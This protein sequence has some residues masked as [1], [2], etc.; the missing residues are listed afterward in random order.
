MDD[1]CS[2][3]IKKKMAHTRSKLAEKLETLEEQIIEPT[4][5]AVTETATSVKE[6]V[7]GTAEAVKMVTSALDLSAHVRE[8]PWRMMG[9]GVLTGFLLGHFLK[10]TA[11]EVR[12]QHNDLSPASSQTDFGVQ[13][14]SHDQQ[15][16]RNGA[17]APGKT[18]AESRLAD[19]QPPP[20]T[21]DGWSRFATDI[22][23]TL[24][25]ALAPVCQGLIGAALADF[26]RPTKASESRKQLRE[27]VFSENREHEWSEPD[28]KRDPEWGGRLR[29]TPR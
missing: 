11:S 15:D 13:Q 5:T 23:S 1:P 18:A 25:H 10:P 3:D 4:A 8:H 7:G 9:T 2:E 24:I 28:A 20:K 17:Y 6:A 19:S 21:G 29:S 12:S 14:E 26:L 16:R 22:Q 27:D